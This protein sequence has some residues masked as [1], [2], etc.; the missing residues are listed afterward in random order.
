MREKGEWN[1]DDERKKKKK[2]INEKSAEAVGA[3]TNIQ[4]FIKCVGVS[5]IQYD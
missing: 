4:T 5:G 1:F 3:S 2:G